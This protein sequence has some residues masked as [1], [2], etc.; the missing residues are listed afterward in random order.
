MCQLHIFFYIL[1]YLHSRLS[2]PN[3]MFIN[4]DSDVFL[5]K[6]LYEFANEGPSSLP[7]ASVK[8]FVPKIE[9]SAGTLPM[10]FVNVTKVSVFL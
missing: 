6:H 8:Y 3:T 1:V 9:I 5:T 2:D 10:V 7:K 4:D